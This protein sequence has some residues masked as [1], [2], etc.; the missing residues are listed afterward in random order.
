MIYDDYID[1]DDDNE[2]DNASL[3][4]VH[5]S[6][7]S[8][9]PPPSLRQ[10]FGGNSFPGGNCQQH[11]VKK[12]CALLFVNLETKQGSSIITIST[13]CEGNNNRSKD[14]FHKVRQVSSMVASLILVWPKIIFFIIVVVVVIVIIVV[15][16]VIIITIIIIIIITPAIVKEDSGRISPHS[17][18]VTQSSMDGT[19][20][21]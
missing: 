11:S 8:R 9:S 13:H 19:V 5:R 2:E 20:H 6:Q 21:L 7:P 3:T 12:L 1:V 16:I 18:L 4:R 14:I 10:L 17:M 15:I